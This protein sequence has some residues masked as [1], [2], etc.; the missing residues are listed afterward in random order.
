MTLCIA[1]VYSALASIGNRSGLN[2]L[3]QIVWMTVLKVVKALN[4]WLT[5]PF[6]RAHD[7]EGTINRGGN[8]QNEINPQSTG[9]SFIAPI[10]NRK[11]LEIYN[12]D[13]HEVPHINNTHNIIFHQHTPWCLRIGHCATCYYGDMYRWWSIY[14]PKSPYYDAIETSWKAVSAMQPVN[15]DMS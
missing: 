6:V 2:H 13:M 15:K 5:T 3:F 12:R 8:H 14:G 1:L 7:S 9:A 10:W 4:A 11:P